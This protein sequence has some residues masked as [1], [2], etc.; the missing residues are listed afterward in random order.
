MAESIE[1]TAL[2]GSRNQ[3]EAVRSQMEK[4]KGEFVDP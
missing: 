4:R 2:I 3:I 1:Q